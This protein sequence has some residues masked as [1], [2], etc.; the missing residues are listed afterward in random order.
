M[1]K[2]L[3]RPL[4]RDAYLKK[5]KKLDVKKF[6]V[7]GLSEVDR[8]NLLLTPITSALL[9][10]RKA[11]GES[12]LGALARTL[13]Q[14]MAAVPT[15]AS[16]IRDLEDDDEKVDQYELVADEDLPPE[17][18]GK[19]AYQRNLRTMKLEK[20]G[21]EKEEKSKDKFR[22]LTPEEAT[23]EFGPAYNPDFLYQ[24][25]LVT[26]K[27]DILGKS[28]TT[29]NVGNEIAPYDKKIGEEL[30]K[31]DV[32]EF[33]D[34]RKLFNN[35]FEV[36]NMLDQIDAV[37]ELP[38]G[39]LKTGALAELALSVDKFA[40]AFGVDTDFQ[41]VGPA[42]LLNTISSKITIDKLQGFSGAISN[43]ELD[44]VANASQG[45]RMSRDG[46]RLN[47]MLQRRGNEINKKFYLEVVE[48][49]M[50]ANK[51]LQGKLNGK[52]YGQLKKEFRENN[53]LVT[54]EIRQAILDTENKIDPEFA[55]NII[56][57]DETGLQ[58]IKIGPNRYIPY[59]P[60]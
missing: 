20:I 10:A 22:I 17:L 38:E 5:E 60:G 1:N 46:I 41:A 6:K 57:D 7:G 32:Q 9:Q 37:L 39:D 23:E 35:S 8:R 16:Q 28:G 44:F 3:L 53:P 15:V 31:Q 47:N 36:N 51:G 52:T 11:P 18:Q 45:L 24:K 55:K 4:F 34:A 2:V 12:E 43:K 26:D 42:E 13:G 30:A 27:I 50:E 25:N 29:V 58:F 33:G 59:N 40:N 56:T 21:R 19:G 54:D 49:F 14:G 48:P